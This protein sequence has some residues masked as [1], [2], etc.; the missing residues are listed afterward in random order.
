MN[1]IMYQL[2]CEHLD[3]M[4]FYMVDLTCKEYE[5]R[6]QVLLSKGQAKKINKL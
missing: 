1:S 2:F 5:S 6:K 3:R 4:A